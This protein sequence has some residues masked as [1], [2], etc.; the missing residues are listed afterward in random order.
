ML[1]KFLTEPDS[2]TGGKGPIMANEFTAESE[3]AADENITAESESAADKSITAESESAADKSITAEPESAAGNEDNPSQMTAEAFKEYISGIKDK[4]PEDDL[5]DAGTPD[6]AEDEPENADESEP[7][8]DKSEG[9][10]TQAEVDAIVK[11]RIAENNRAM[12]KR[13]S[14]YDELGD[15]AMRFYGG[16]RDEAVKQMLADLRGQNAEQMGMSEEKY[17]DMRRTED[18]ARRYDEQERAR[19]DAQAEQDAIIKRWREQSDELKEIVPDFDFVKAMENA[20][21]KKAIFAGKSVSAAYMLSNKERAAKPQRKSIRQEAA[22][23]QPA[24]AKAE[25]DPTS[26]SDKDFNDYINKI[27]RIE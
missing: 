22:K 1:Y 16:N 8:R 10:L 4:E 12:S 5:P 26:A 19:N 20:D 6:G 7:E 24:S 18:K 17:A 23:R 21:F 11:S 14:V 2:V 9:K 13:Y 25:F 3:L 15:E 27:R